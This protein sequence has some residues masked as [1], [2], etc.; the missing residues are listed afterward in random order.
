[1]SSE[2]AQKFFQLSGKKK[3]SNEENDQVLVEEA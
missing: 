1:M 3:E 2:S